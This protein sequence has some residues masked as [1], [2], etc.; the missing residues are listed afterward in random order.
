M[1]ESPPVVKIR[2]QEGKEL[3]GQKFKIINAKRMNL[4]RSTPFI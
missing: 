4:V 2:Y 1:G 3:Y